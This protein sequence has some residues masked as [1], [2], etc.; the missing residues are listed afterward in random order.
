MTAFEAGNYGQFIVG[1]V[2]EEGDGH[3]DATFECAGA[4]NGVYS[5]LAW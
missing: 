3:D 1:G 4:R 2:R 5:S